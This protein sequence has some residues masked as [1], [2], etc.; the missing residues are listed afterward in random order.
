MGVAQTL[1]PSHRACVRRQVPQ[2]AADQ[3]A[4]PAAVP[5]G[6]GGGEQAPPQRDEGAHPRGRAAGAPLHP[7]THNELSLSLRR[8]AGAR[9][10]RSILGWEAGARLL[11]LTGEGQGRVCVCPDVLTLL[12]CCAF[13]FGIMRFCSV[14]CLLWRTPWSHPPYRGP[15]FAGT[16][17]RVAAPVTLRMP[18]LPF[19]TSVSSAG[20]APLVIRLL[21]GDVALVLTV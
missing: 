12:T 6:R 21:G 5:G 8:I 18:S 3:R 7:I 11:C 17:W 19:S 4:A 13:G 2:R 16:C 14:L 10:A 9:G 15:H 1:T 20:Q